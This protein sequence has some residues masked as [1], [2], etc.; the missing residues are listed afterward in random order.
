M[1]VL[2]PSLPPPLFSTGEELTQLFSHAP[3]AT[4]TFD[5]LTEDTTIAEVALKAAVAPSQCE[6]QHSTVCHALT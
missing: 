4:L 2:P 1:T 3:T 6:Q 5:H